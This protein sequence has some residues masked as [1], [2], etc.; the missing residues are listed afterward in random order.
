MASEA[1]QI[2]HLVHTGHT[3]RI[4]HLLGVLAA[5]SVHQQEIGE[6]GAREH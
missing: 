6:M 1:R 2:P 5:C 3:D 4:E